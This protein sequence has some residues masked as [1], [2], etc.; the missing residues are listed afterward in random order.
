MSDVS[1]S[2]PASCSH[3]YTLSFGGALPGFHQ[4]SAEFLVDKMYT[5]S[6]CHE[7]GPCLLVY[8]GILH[9]RASRGGYCMVFRGV[10]L[11]SGSRKKRKPMEDF[12]THQNTSHVRAHG[13]KDVVAPKTPPG[14]AF[15]RPVIIHV[16]IGA[17]LPGTNRVQWIRRVKRNMYELAFGFALFNSILLQSC[18]LSPKSIKGSKLV[19]I[20]GLGCAHFELIS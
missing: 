11:D 6:L 14:P 1:F 9:I 19:P 10:S 15:Q 4:A 17:V 5:P 3:T 12:V 7:P 18:L 13:I 16:S 2:N 8:I 20:I